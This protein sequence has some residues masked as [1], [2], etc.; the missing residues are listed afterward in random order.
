MK[1]V[2]LYVHQFL[3]NTKEIERE[4]KEK[5]DREKEKEEPEKE[6]KKRGR[7]KI[8]N[9]LKNPHKSKI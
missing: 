6:E 3:P 5:Y 9:T 4:R 1:Q 8:Q 7:K 2:A